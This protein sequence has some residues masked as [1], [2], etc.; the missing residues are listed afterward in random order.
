MT[1]VKLLA[2]V[3]TVTIY[4]LIVGQKFINFSTS[5]HQLQNLLNKATIQ[6]T[7]TKDHT[8]QTTQTT[9]LHYV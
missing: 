4:A 6:T 1:L 2:F 5:F 8:L 3:L 7:E 9:T